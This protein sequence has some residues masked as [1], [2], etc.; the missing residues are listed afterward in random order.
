MQ[1]RCRTGRSCAG[2]L[3]AQAAAKLTHCQHHER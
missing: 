2:L 1:R 3:Q